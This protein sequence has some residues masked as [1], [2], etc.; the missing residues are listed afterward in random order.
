MTSQSQTPVGRIAQRFATLRAEGRT[1]FIPF[2]TAGDPDPDTS[3]ALLSR[4]PGAGADLIEL[5]VPFTD[6]MADGPAIQ[7]AS[8][9]ALKAGMTLTRTLDLVRRFR[10][11]GF[12]TPVIL[13]GYFNPVHAYGAE[14]FL[15]DAVDV[16][17]D[18]LIIVD[19]PPEEEDGLGAVRPDGL[20]LIRLATPTTDEARLGAVLRGASGFLYYVSVTGVTGAGSAA[21]D[22][23][24]DAAARLR[25]NTDLPIAIGFGIKT[26]EQAAEAGAIGDA[27]VVGSAL[28]GRITDHLTAD[29]TAKPGLTDAVE[30]FA[31][32]LSAAVHGAPKQS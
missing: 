9:R 32:D 3:Y 28:V 14:R 24:R 18:G 6:P 1:A 29:G 7:E 31:R 27:V 13:M 11:D 4:L 2:L 26:P 12:D 15:R 10:A 23:L 30:G 17:V 20:D 8:L 19:L 5:G 25:R 16:G 21:E 22:A